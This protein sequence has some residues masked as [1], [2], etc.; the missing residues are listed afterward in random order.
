MRGILIASAS[1]AVRRSLV[2]VL[3]E[4]CTVYEVDT[5]GEA[6]S[7]AGA[8]RMD[9][10][11]FDDTFADGDAEMLASRLNGLEYGYEMVPLVLSDQERYLQRFR[12]YGVRYA[13]TKPFNVQRIQDV[14]GQIEA[15]TAA[16][17][18]SP[19]QTAPPPPP[20]LHADGNSHQPAEY[21]PPPPREIIREVSHRFRRLL[22]RS[23]D[24]DSLVET[25]IEALQ[26]QFDTDHVVV[27][28]PARDAPCYRVVCSPNAQRNRAA[29]GLSMGEP[30]L[31]HVIRVGRPVSLID[32][33]GLDSQQ[34]LKARRIAER[35]GIQHLCPVLSGG[36]AMA[37]VGIGGMVE[38][39]QG[40]DHATLRLF[41]S[42]FSKALEN[43]ELHGRVS[44]AESTYH[45]VFARFPVG[46]VAVG[47]DGTVR[48]VNERAAQILGVAAEDVLFQPVEKVGSHVADALREVLVTGKEVPAR[49]LT[50]GR[51][52]F[53]LSAVPL[54][55]NA[56]D[57]ASLAILDAAPAAQAP[58]ES[59]PA[60][61]VDDAQILAGLAQ[62]LAHNFKNAMVPI[63]T[64]AELLSERYH[65]EGFRTSF[66]NVVEENTRKIDDWINRLL[67]FCDL[68]SSATTRQTVAVADMVDEA[69]QTAIPDRETCRVQIER[70]VDPSVGVAGHAEALTQALVE[71]LNNALDSLQESS[72]PRL[73]LHAKWGQ[74]ETVEIGVQDNGTGIAQE[75][76][77]DCFRPFHTNKLSGLGL[78]LA[79]VQRIVQ[80]HGGTV[81]VS[82]ASTTGTRVTL[83]LPAVKVQ[84]PVL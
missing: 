71:V 7:R 6:L 28:L 3:G 21:P 84:A 48:D 42:F 14:L 68:P 70:D 43:A 60:E 82:P 72:E 55:P 18:V 45:Q 74:G 77:G 54:G 52:Q 11:F 49:W 78:G 36:R 80:Q 26:E 35:L 10:I 47:P 1:P 41:I 79:F 9:V 75:E 44:T 39:E 8:E 31:A 61:A 57:G 46:A 64:C 23:L 62:V 40:S 67:S 83:K 13:V 76:V 38:N 24:R 66:F 15:L 53:N 2:A 19:E 56:Q 22:S 81:D 29:Y 51:G 34:R 59:A 16:L 27:L 17:N 5:V 25:F 33:G 37:L 20:S 73:Q 69:L 50:T 65:L 63:R 32:P 12:G 58:S 4:E 30:L